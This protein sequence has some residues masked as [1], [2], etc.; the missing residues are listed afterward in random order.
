MNV[1]ENDLN[2]LLSLNDTDFA[3]PVYQRNYAW[4]TE[5]CEQL[6][7]DILSITSTEKQHFL[8]RKKNLKLFTTFDL[9]LN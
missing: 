5:Q 8:G 6:L 1:K 7:A 2:A 4:N 3:I 9:P